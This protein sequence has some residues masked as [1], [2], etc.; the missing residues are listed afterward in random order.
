MVGVIESNEEVNNFG[1]VIHGGAGSFSGL[2][3]KAI[4]SYETGI[5]EALSAGFKILKQ[6]GTS[7]DA[8]TTAI[9]ILEDLPLFK[10][11]NFE[12]TFELNISQT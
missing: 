3:E 12:K 7:L 11:N 4:N 1:I 9:V 5:N 6:G 8:V 2:D 10:R